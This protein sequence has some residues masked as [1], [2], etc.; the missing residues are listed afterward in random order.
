MSDYGGSSEISSTSQATTIR[1]EPTNTT[2]EGSSDSASSVV[3]VLPISVSKENMILNDFVPV[4]EEDASSD[5]SSGLFK[6]DALVQLDSV[7]N[8]IRTNGYE[9]VQPTTS[10]ND[11]VTKIEEDIKSSF[12]K[13]TLH[14]GKDESLKQN[15]INE[16]NEN[17]DFI[18]WLN[19]IDDNKQVRESKLYFFLFMFFIPG[20]ISLYNSSISSNSR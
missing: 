8:E 17:I 15:S 10:E 19:D 14:M 16:K 4:L 7:V 9:T 12:S 20:A 13:K 5:N 18:K 3:I 2:T 1:D 6:N 11:T